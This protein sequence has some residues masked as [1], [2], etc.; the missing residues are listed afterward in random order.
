MNFL[1]LAYSRPDCIIKLLPACNAL[2]WAPQGVF[3]SGLIDLSLPPL[4]ERGSR[5]TMSVRGGQQSMS[6]NMGSR[7]VADV[8]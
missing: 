2:S 3:A 7:A 6:K 8:D 5:L 4:N 1:S